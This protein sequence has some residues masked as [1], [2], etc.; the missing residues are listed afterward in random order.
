MEEKKEEKKEEKR[1]EPKQYYSLREV[2]ILQTKKLIDLGVS[3]ND[4]DKVRENILKMAKD[5]LLSISNDFKTLATK[6]SMIETLNK[7]DFEPISR[8][9][10]VGLPIK[11]P[12]KEPP[13]LMD[14]LMPT[15]EEEMFMVISK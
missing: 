13:V 6:L 9:L 14:F 3:P 10:S 8:N 4:T 12:S 15:L 5:V 1:E 2:R 11:N 7:G